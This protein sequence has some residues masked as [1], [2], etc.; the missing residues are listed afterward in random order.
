MYCTI[1]YNICKAPLHQDQSAEKSKPKRT[2]LQLITSDT[3]K[4]GWVLR[5]TISDAYREVVL[6]SG[7]NTGESPVV[8][9]WECSDGWVFG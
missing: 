5:V 2:K 3:N 4:F 1:Q 9:R 7:S 8:G 6:N